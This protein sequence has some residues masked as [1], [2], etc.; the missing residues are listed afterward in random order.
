MVIAIQVYYVALP[1]AAQQTYLQTFA[2]YTQLLQDG[3]QDLAWWDMR[4]GLS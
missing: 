1:T 4:V 3:V 2:S